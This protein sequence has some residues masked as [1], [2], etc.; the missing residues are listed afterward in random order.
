MNKVITIDQAV[1]IAAQRKSEGKTIVLTNGCFDLLHVGH[2]RYLEAAHEEGDVLIV[3]LNSD[4]SVRNLKG[5]SRPVMGENERAEILSALTCVDYVVIFDEATVDRV[6]ERIRP[7]I[8]AKGT[9]YTEESVP[10][11]ETIARVGGRVAIVGDPKDHSTKD[12]LKR[13]REL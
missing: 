11:R 12:F 6:I 13:I 4:E 2:I 10:E 1:E 9:D 8:H 7:S 5:P 3:A